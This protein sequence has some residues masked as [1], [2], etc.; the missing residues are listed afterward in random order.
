MRILDEKGNE[1]ESYDPEKGYVT[2]EEINS[3]YHPAQEFVEEQG[4]YKTVTEYPN[5]GKD[6]EWVIDVP[7]QEAKEAYYDKETIQR[8]HPYSDDEL[9]K[10]KAEKEEAEEQQKKLNSLFSSEMTIGDIV[11]TLAE[12]TYGGDE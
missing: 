4:H 2:Q 5:G 12:L 3:T 9:A 10:R 8:Y 1:L 11:D 7:G 6:V